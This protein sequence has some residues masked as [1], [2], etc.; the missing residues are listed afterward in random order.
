MKIT[1]AVKIVFRE[2]EFCNGRRDRDFRF[3]ISNL[4]AAKR[5]FTRM[6]VLKI[7]RHFF[8]KCIDCPRPIPG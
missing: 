3:H 4:F 8:S 1:A 5:F 2:L 7:W 6:F